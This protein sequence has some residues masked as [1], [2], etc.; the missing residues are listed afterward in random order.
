M[1]YKSLEHHHQY[2]SR[3]VVVYPIPWPL[4]VGKADLPACSSVT[5]AG[6]VHKSR[7]V[8]VVCMWVQLKRWCVS[9]VW[10][11]QRRHSADGCD[12]TST[13]CMYEL[14]KVDLFVLSWARVD[15]LHDFPFVS[16]GRERKRRPYGIG[17]ARAGLM[18]DL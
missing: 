3:D 7:G 11:L 5:P 18:T 4:L 9:C 2:K 13:L 17:N 8:N 14:R 6:S 15:V 10:M 1:H 12:L 16:V